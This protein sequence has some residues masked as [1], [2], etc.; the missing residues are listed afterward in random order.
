M[1]PVTTL[2]RGEELQRPL[3]P[4]YATITVSDDLDG[5]YVIAEFLYVLG[6]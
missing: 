6:C 2:Q 4:D 3:N 5:L 1:A